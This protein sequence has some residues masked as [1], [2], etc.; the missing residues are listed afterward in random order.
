M[1]STL[2]LNQNSLTS[3]TLNVRNKDITGSPVDG[4]RQCEHDSEIFLA[5]SLRARDTQAIEPGIYVLSLLPV[6]R[7]EVT[8]TG[9]TRTVIV[10]R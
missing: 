1:R 5:P 6:R 9:T 2:S 8:A 3:L 4:C 10:P 7:E